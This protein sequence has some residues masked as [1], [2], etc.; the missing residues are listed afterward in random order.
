[1]KDHFRRTLLLRSHAII[2]D[3]T[4]DC[5]LLIIEMGAD[6]VVVRS[7]DG[8]LHRFVV[9]EAGAMQIQR[10]DARDRQDGSERKMAST[11]RNLVSV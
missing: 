6:A 3:F 1:M 5:M 11:G 7:Q 9:D 2:A 4:I 8:R 10:S